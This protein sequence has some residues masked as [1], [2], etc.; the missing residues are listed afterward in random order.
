LER[1]LRVGFRD[2]RG[3]VGRFTIC[4]P[5]YTS[6]RP[7]WRTG[8][9]VFRSE[10]PVC[11][12]AT[13][14]PRTGGW[15]LDDSLACSVGYAFRGILEERGHEWGK[16]WSFRQELAELV[17]EEYGVIVRAHRVR[18]PASNFVH[19]ANPGTLL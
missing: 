4:S 12:E 11:L 18:R 5:E 13:G 19:K 2:A 10:V 9:G 17:R 3:T 15:T 16:G 7:Y 6:A 8:S 14:G 1:P